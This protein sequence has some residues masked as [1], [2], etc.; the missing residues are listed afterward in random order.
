MM[1]NKEDDRYIWTALQAK[2]PVERV[3]VK[4]S[5]TVEAVLSRYRA[6]LHV[7]ESNSKIG[8]DALIT[9]F[10]THAFQYQLLGETLKTFGENMSHQVMPEAIKA[11]LTNDPDQTVKNLMDHF[12]IL[13][14]F[15]APDDSSN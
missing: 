15:V 13:H 9:S 10:N 12:I 1:V 4:L 14:P 6:L 5:L 7:Q 3:A 2:V 8:I 11:Q